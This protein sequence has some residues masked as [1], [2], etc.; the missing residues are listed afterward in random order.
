MGKSIVVCGSGK[1]RADIAMLCEQLELGLDGVICY[2]P[3]LLLQEWTKSPFTS[4]I[5][6]GL[7]YDHFQKIRIADVVF[8]YNY[9]GYV[10]PSTA[11]EIGFAVALGKPIWALEQMPHEPAINTL[12]SRFPKTEPGPADICYLADRLRRLLL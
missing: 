8:V 2:A 4:Y 9:D 6:M 7:S 10:G 5:G 12:F 11:M 1:F 3:H